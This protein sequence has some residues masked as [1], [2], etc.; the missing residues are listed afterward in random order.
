MVVR[1]SRRG[2]RLGFAVAIGLTFP[3]G[4]AFVDASPAAVSSTFV[5]WAAYL[6]GSEHSSYASTA[7]AITPANAASLQQR[8]HWTPDPPTL[9]GQ[10]AAV[11]EASPTV[12]NGVVYLGAETGD[13]YALD[14]NTGR[15][16]WK[17]L[18]GFSHSAQ[19]PP[20]GIT[21]TA[22]VSP[23][24]TTRRLTVYVAS[25]N[26]NLDALDAATGASV[27]HVVVPPS[28]A[29]LGSYYAWS[30]PTVAGNRVYVGLASR[31]DNPLVRGGLRAYDQSTGA[32]VATYFSVPAGTVGGS[33]WSSALVTSDGHVVVTTGNEG[34]GKRIG[35][36][37]SIVELSAISLQRQQAWQVSAADLGHD[38]DFGGSATVFTATLSGVATPM[39]GACNKDGHYYALREAAVTSGPVWARAL[40]SPAWVAKNGG[41]CIA[42]AA[43]DPSTSALYAAGNTTTIAG[44]TSPGSIRRL[45]PSTGQPL[46]E[47]GLPIGHAL[48]S[49][50]VDGAG[51]VAVGTRGTDGRVFLVD[52]T[53]GSILASLAVGSVFA[54]PVFA[55]TGLF[56]ASETGGLSEF[57]P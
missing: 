42:A 4:T 3:A 5:N 35:D 6:N 31:C 23:D 55:D 32:L 15:V 18:L 34:G 10:P 40:G 9:S 16:L 44:T 17:R 21:S 2:S 36:S 19:C 57:G 52:H 47:T 13:M 33:V 28:S 20:L 39:V 38:S 45:D 43:W 7:L 51:I 54:Q 37:L 29:K 53:S 14:E 30:S 11:L 49:P 26:G 22:T 25:G 12:V 41:L 50:S 8:W 48:G 56:V 1:A 27:W 24:P 46:W